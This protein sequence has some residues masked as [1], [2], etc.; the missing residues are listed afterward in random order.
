MT[1]VEE[2]TAGTPS[3]G[4]ANV[5]L[6]TT[7]P[8]G[9]FWFTMTVAVFSMGVPLLMFWLGLPI[10]MLGMMMWRGGARLE[11]AR[12]RT[13]LNRFIAEPYRPLPGGFMQD[14]KARAKDPATWRDMVYLVLL[15]PIGLFWF[16]SFVTLW[17]VGLGLTTLWIWFRYLPNGEAPLLDWGQGNGPV[18]L[19]NSTLDA[20]PWAIGGL[21]VL[22]ATVFLSRAAAKLHGRFAQAMLAPTWGQLRRADEQYRERFDATRTYPA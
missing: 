4:A 14:M 18:I 9:I 8:L 20:L 5:Y 13:L 21:L 7:L 15:F 16:I 12:A 1:T 17:A 10:A 11:R 3:V 22:V 2:T 19:V 6:L